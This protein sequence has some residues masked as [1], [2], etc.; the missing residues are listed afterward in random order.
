MDEDGV[1]GE[2]RDILELSNSRTKSLR[3]VGMSM[4]IYKMEAGS[5]AYTPSHVDFVDVVKNVLNELEDMAG[6]LSVTVDV[7]LDDGSDLKK[8][9]W[10][11]WG[12]IFCMNQCLPIC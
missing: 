11:F 1:Q 2:I 12:R 8:Q 10:W 6:G 7:R 4:M 5:Y 3:M 9:A